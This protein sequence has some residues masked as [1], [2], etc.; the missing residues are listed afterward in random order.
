[1]YIRERRLQIVARV[2]MLLASSGERAGGE[3]GRE[4]CQ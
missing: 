1:M 3:F 4:C 2:Q